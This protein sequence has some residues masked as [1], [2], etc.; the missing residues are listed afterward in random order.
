M[1][2]LLFWRLMMWLGYKKPGFKVG[3]MVVERKDLRPYEQYFQITAINN[4]I[5]HYRFMKNTGRYAG[6]GQSPVYL[7]DKT[8]KSTA[9]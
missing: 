3:D 7:M 1:I 4:D 9:L 5:Y 2:K 6:E 8:Y